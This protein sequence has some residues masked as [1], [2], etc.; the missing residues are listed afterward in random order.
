LI[1]G[2]DREECVCPLGI[3]ALEM[4]ELRLGGGDFRCEQVVIG[5]LSVIFNG[6]FVKSQD[7]RVVFGLVS[8]GSLAACGGCGSG[9][10][11]G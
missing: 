8:G 9:G 2:S 3:L 4:C 5:N 7:Q 1:G 11:G 10:C 6:L